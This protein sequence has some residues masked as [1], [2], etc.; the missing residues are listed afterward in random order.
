MIIIFS[1]SCGTDTTQDFL[2]VHKYIQYST[3]YS[4]YTDIHGR[5]QCAWSP[6]LNIIVCVK[7]RIE[8]YSTVV[9][10]SLT[11]LYTVLF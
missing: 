7:W 5:F 11:V 9:M 1:E 4:D 3:V 2:L 8:L 6:S 10:P